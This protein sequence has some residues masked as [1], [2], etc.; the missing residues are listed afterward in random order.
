MIFKIAAGGVIAVILATTLRGHNKEMSLVLSLAAC[1][2]LV[3]GGLQMFQTALDY[4]RK[5]QQAAK[6]ETAVLTPV[7]KVCGI[8]VLTQVCAL[9]CCQAGDGAVGK[10]IELCGGAA[11]VCAMMPLL[12]A[13]LE[14]IGELLGG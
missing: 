5:M 13:V 11:A 3:L 2:I 12:D 6:I 8:G 9:F 14:L 10:I 4:I 1:V 7:L